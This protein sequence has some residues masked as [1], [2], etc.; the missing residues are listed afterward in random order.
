[1]EDRA[2]EATRY[3]KD[4]QARLCAR[5]EGLEP[6]KRFQATSWTKPAEHRLKGGGEM[7]LIRGDAIEKGGVNV[8]HVWGKLSEAGIAQLPGASASSG[9]FSACG[10]SVVVHPRNPFAP[11]AHM[12]LRY[13]RTSF[14]WM[15]GG[16]DLTPAI[17]IA[18]DTTDFHAA[19]RTACAGYRAD[20]YEQYRE[21]CDR[22][23][24]L[25]HRNE[26]RGVGGVFFDDLRSGDWDADFSFQRAIGE[27]FLEVYPAILERRIHTPFT[28]A[29]SARQL[30]KRSRYVEF[31]LVYDR[32]T[33]FGFMTDANPEAYLMSLPPQAGW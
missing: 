25:P 29:D 24:F 15:G 27:A 32:G 2:A 12:N 18:A 14:D 4:L 33:R 11:I 13:L 21:W 16:A 1:M 5:L 10:I 19:L 9:E 3:F 17:E 20:A 30:L 6:V 26:R 22:Y 23:F 31:N 28:P 8:S 7:R